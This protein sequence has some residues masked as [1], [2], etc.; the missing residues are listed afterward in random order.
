[1]RLTLR[2]LPLLVPL[3][4]PH[5]LEPHYLHQES[6]IGKVRKVSERLRIIVLNFS[7]NIPE[8]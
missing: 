3:G 4:S 1:M 2:D 5:A 8:K 7:P 6:I